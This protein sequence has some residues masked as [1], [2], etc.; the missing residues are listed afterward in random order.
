M[1]NLKAI[2]IGALLLIFILIFSFL[3]FVAF[4]KRSLENKFA[5]FALNTKTDS[6][7]ILDYINEIFWKFIKIFSNL[8]SKSKL[9]N[10][11]SKN[12]DKFISYSDSSKI[13]AIDILTIKILLFF[14]SFVTIFLFSIFDLVILDYYYIVII[15]LLFYFLPNLILSTKYTSLKRC[16]ENDIL[17]AVII[18]N[19]ALKNGATISQAIDLV[20]VELDGAISDEF[21]KISVDLKYGLSISN[22]FMRFHNRV[23]LDITYFIS[24][25]LINFDDIGSEIVHIFNYIE[26]ELLSESNLRNEIRSA[27]SGSKLIYYI[28]VLM[29]LLL[30]VFVWIFDISIISELLINKIGLLIFIGIIILYIL[31]L[32][33]VNKVMRYD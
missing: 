15:A 29:P 30:L 26:E 3:Y 28:C 10:I 31:Y 33:I 1:Q 5:Q 8:F 4:R 32:V 25:T 22:A 14:F 2:V 7:S 11:H 13:K 21:K 20:S 9:L 18:I 27:T 24:D 12:F 23:D 16:I 17:S 19:G 6:L